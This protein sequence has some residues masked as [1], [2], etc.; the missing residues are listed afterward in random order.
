MIAAVNL[1]NRPLYY[2]WPAGDPVGLQT[3][4]CDGYDEEIDYKC[5]SWAN[6]YLTIA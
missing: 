2:D 5:P 3:V 1:E 6:T 4:Y